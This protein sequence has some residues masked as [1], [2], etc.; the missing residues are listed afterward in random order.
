[1][2]STINQELYVKEIIKRNRIRIYVIDKDKEI[3]LSDV[4]ADEN[5]SC[6]FVY[7]DNYIVSYTREIGTNEIP[8]SIDGVYDIH[9][10]QVIVNLKENDKKSLTNMMLIR[11]KFNL[12]VVLS[13]INNFDWDDRRTEFEKY[14]TSGNDK[15]SHEQIIEYILKCYPFLEKYIGLSEDLSIKD[16]IKIENQINQFNFL[17]YA[18]PQDLMLTNVVNKENNFCDKYDSYVTEYEHVQ[19]LMRLRK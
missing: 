12:S 8:L 10:S 4:K 13:E 7:N 3:L 16:Y 9:K 18:I 5:F 19:K 14:L 6:K 17:F 15:I 2:I 11:K 1:M